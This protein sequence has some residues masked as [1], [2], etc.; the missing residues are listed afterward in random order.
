[1]PQPPLSSGSL[2]SRSHMG[3]SCGTCF[4]EQRGWLVRQSRGVRT[5]THTHTQCG[6]GHTAARLAPTPAQCAA[7]RGARRRAACARQRAGLPC[8]AASHHA[9]SPATHLLHP[10]QPA[11]VV[12]RVQRGRQPAVQAED[13]RQKIGGCGG[14][15]RASQRAVLRCS[16]LRSNAVVC[17]C[18]CVVCATGWRRRARGHAA[19]A[20]LACRVTPCPQRAP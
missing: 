6:A 8:R 3:P 5:H 12:Q 15:L 17:V 1:M 10:V 11:Y 9:S 16:V 4:V 14:A 2:H 18:V 13:L 20:S 7:Q 19:A